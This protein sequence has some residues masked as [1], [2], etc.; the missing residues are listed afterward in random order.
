MWLEIHDVEGVAHRTLGSRD[1]DDVGII[2]DSLEHLV[3]TVSSR[4][5][6]GVPLFREAILAEVNPHEI[7]FIEDA[8]LLVLVEP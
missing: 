6:F 5:E 7:S 4:L 8:S 1:V 2:V 3:G